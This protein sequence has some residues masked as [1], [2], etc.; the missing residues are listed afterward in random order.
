MTISYSKTLAATDPIFSPN[1]GQVASVT[2]II[3]VGTADLTQN[4]TFDICYVPPNARVLD[5]FLVATDMDSGSSLTIIV[6]DSGDTD[7]F[8]NAGTIGQT[9]MRMDFGNNATAAASLITH[10]GTNYTSATKIY[11]TFSNAPGTAVAGTIAA[12][13]F[14]T[15]VEPP[16]TI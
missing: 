8:I 7:R 4:T 13:V 2:Q 1:A 15:V 6:G 14:Y 3:T 12:T 10:Q 11:G 9:A 5:G 16:G